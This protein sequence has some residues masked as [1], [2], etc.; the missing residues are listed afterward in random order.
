MEYGDI[1]RQ[2]WRIVR[3]ERALWGFGAISAV[4]GLVG[5]AVIA[6]V[7]VMGGAVAAMGQILATQGL[8]SGGSDAEF[9]LMLARG[10]DAVA[11]WMPAFIAGLMVVMLLWLFVAIFDVAGGAGLISQ[12]DAALKGQPTSFGDGMARGFSAWGRVAALLALSAAPALVAALVQSLATF[13]STT[14]PLLAGE[15]PDPVTMMFANQ[16][17]SGVG[18]LVSLLAVPVGVLAVVALRWVVLEDMGWRMALGRSWHTCKTRFA[19]VA[20]MYLVLLAVALGVGIVLALAAGVL[21][22]VFGTV[23]VVLAIAESMVAAVL[24]GVV[25]LLLLTGVV[26]LSQ[27]ALAVVMSVAWTVFWRRLTAPAEQPAVMPDLSVT[28]GDVR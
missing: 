9:D 12:A 20:L 24:L 2:S 27:G 28:E 6:I 19:D 18:S 17:A 21:V 14:L 7:A 23:V 3:A 10:F 5:G 4:Q 25:G 11:P 15:T 1:I 13:G 22:A 8:E 16:A 26:G